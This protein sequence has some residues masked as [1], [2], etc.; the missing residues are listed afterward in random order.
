[1]A[2]P[3]GNSKTG[4]GTTLRHHYP[5]IH[6]RGLGGGTQLKSKFRS[7]K[8]DWGHLTFCRI[9]QANVDIRVG[10]RRSWRCLCS[11]NSFTTCGIVGPRQSS[12][13]S[14]S[15]M[16]STY[17]NPSKS[18]QNVCDAKSVF[19]HHEKLQVEK[20]VLKDRQEKCRLR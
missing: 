19:Q 7:K 20:F 13:F 12:L 3:R 5:L 9:A 18:F 4:T 16:S 6:H 11:N 1:M 14:E 10:H 15:N 8:V 2:L 17:T